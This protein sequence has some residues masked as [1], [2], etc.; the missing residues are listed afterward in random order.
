MCDPSSTL[1]WPSFNYQGAS[2]WF[3]LLSKLESRKPKLKADEPTW[4]TTIISTPLYDNLRNATLRN[5]TLSLV[6]PSPR[7]R[8]YSVQISLLVVTFHISWDLTIESSAN[9]FKPH[10]RTHHIVITAIIMCHY[11]NV[12]Y[13][14]F[15]ECH[16][17][18]YISIITHPCENCTPL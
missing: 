1:C 4:N 16:T 11:C 18:H 13:V 8:M 9:Y 6:S 3:S 2:C 10:I 14:W 15:H 5:V 7:E 17:L 12:G